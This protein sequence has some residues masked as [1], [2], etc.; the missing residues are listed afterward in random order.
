MLLSPGSSENVSKI[1]V[2]NREPVP[3]Y[4]MDRNDDEIGAMMVSAPSCHC[5]SIRVLQLKLV[6]C[7]LPLE[8]L[9]LTMKTVRAS[10]RVWLFS[11]R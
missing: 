10:I 7:Q 4:R 11:L 2:K 6:V 1:R 5:F 9:E 3:S 8:S